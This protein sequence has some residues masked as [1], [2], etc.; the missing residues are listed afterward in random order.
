M[1]CILES[2]SDEFEHKWGEFD[3]DAESADQITSR[4]AVCNMDWDRIRAEDLM[5]LFHSFLPPNGIIHSLAVSN[6]W[7]DTVFVSK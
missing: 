2:D 6:V 5:M 3:N 1:L 4:L 7:I